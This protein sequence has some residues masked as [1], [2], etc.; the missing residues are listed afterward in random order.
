MKDVMNLITLT[1][2]NKVREGRIIIGGHSIIFRKDLID[3][4]SDEIIT[5]EVL[6]SLFGYDICWYNKINEEVK[7][8]Q[9]FDITLSLG[10]NF[11]NSV[12]CDRFEDI[13]YLQFKISKFLKLSSIS[14]FHYSE[15]EWIVNEDSNDDLF[16]AIECL[17]NRL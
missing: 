13:Y 3:R 5:I 15:K 16:L 10:H 8:Q 4:L 7:L 14:L 11:V 6:A 17:K 9:S 12:G 2:I 1:Q